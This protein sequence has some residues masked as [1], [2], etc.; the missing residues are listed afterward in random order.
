MVMYM[1]CRKLEVARDFTKRHYGLDY[2]IEYKSNN[3]RHRAVEDRGKSTMKDRAKSD[4][5]R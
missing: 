2:G 5:N 1:H 4:R 3:G